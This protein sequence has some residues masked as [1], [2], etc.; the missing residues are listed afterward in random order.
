VVKSIETNY[1]SLKGVTGASIMGD[2]SVALVLDLLGIEEILFK[3][4]SMRRDL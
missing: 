2:G 3:N 1:R 4:T